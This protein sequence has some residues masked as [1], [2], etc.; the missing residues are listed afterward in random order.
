[1]SKTIT[2]K[3]TRGLSGR[4]FHEGREY[5]VIQEGPAKE[6]E[7]VAYD[8]DILMGQGHAAYDGKTPLSAR[9]DVVKPVKGAKNRI[10]EGEPP[11]P[12]KAD[13]L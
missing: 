2:M 5:T 3:G 13:E 6:D 10:G 12:A 8:A 11:K 9:S 7:I 4:T 1:M